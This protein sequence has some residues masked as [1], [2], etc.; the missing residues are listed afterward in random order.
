MELYPR[1]NLGSPTAA[2][3]C[4]VLIT[5]QGAAKRRPSWAKFAFALAFG[6]V[7]TGLSIPWRFWNGWGGCDT[8]RSASL[9][10]LGPLR[11]EGVKRICG[12]AAVIGLDLL[13]FFI[14]S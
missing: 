14:G 1:G 5:L 9:L 3:C 11:T 13:I 4:A 12:F 6:L 10:V 7:P 2:S 8:K